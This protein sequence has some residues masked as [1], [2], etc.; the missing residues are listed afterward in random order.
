MVCIPNFFPSFKVF[1]ASLVSISHLPLGQSHI[2]NDPQNMKLRL[3]D[4]VI[5]MS[6]FSKV[7]DPEKLIKNHIFLGVVLLI[8]DYHRRF[9]HLI[10]FSSGYLAYAYPHIFFNITHGHV[11]HFNRIRPRQIYIRLHV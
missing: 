2:R 3:F 5:A 11:A 4:F 10:S 1:R 8:L 9:K 7:L 6:P